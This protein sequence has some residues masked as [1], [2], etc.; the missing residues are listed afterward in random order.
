MTARTPTAA[1][2]GG[3]C[4]TS[5]SATKR[6]GGDEGTI[7][8]YFKTGITRSASATDVC[9]VSDTACS[10]FFHGIYVIKLID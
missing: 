7:T 6:G 5:I 3:P 9:A 8:G 4:S 1:S 10:G 2:A